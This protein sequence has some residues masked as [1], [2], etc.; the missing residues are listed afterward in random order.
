MYKEVLSR[1]EGI[2]VFPL[3][4][5][6]IFFTFFLVLIVWV[7]RLN[8]GYLDSMADMPLDGENETMPGLPGSKNRDAGLQNEDPDMNEG[9]LI[10]RNAE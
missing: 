7:F 4:A 2:D 9:K 1:I 6:V 3:I 5:L 8:R 10:N